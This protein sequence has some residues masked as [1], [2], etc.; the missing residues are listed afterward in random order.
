MKPLTALRVDLAKIEGDG[1]FP[2]P[3]CGAMISPDDE[4][5]A[6]YEIVDIETKDDG[7]L[8]DLTILCKKCHSTILLEG[9]DALNDLESSI[10]DELDDY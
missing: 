9:F 6:T 3:A 10:N 4:S 7:S 8:E 1:E 5:E 2:C